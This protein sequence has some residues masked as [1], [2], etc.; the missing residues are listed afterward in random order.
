MR[1]RGG[2]SGGTAERMLGAGSQRFVGT[3]S[4]GRDALR[5][6]VGHFLLASLMGLAAVG[7]AT[8][9]DRSQGDLGDRA[10]I[11]SGKSKSSRSWGKLR[12]LR[13]GSTAGVLSVD[14]VV[15]ERVSEASLSA[16]TTDP[17]LS[18]A[19][20]DD[21][22]L[23]QWVDETVLAAPARRALQANGLRAGR[24]VREDRFREA[25]ARQRA[26]SDVID[27]F[28]REAEISS[29]LSQGSRSLPLRYGRRAEVPLHQPLGGDQVTLVKTGPQLVG[30]TLGNPQLTLA[31]TSRPGDGSRELLLDVRPEIQ[32]GESRQ[33]FISSDS[34][35]RID[36]RREVWRLE[37]L[38]FSS[39]M[40]VGDVLVLSTTAT[41]R[42]VGAQ[43]L[44]DTGSSG[45]DARLY[46]LLRLESVPETSE[47]EADIR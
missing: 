3:T 29:R 17:E 5:P 32:H 33:A 14:F 37:T 12:S 31:L 43:M 46:L 47:S 11:R 21:S 9:T 42:G 22:D 23:W 28:L 41:P 7:C 44:T 25:L 4:P 8:W 16:A 30:K 24:L 39:R 36:T 10:T 34:A 26:Q 2:Q 35:I 45:D 6:A 38:D 15:A 20:A 19:A 13:S 27:D 40:S 18:G 1:T